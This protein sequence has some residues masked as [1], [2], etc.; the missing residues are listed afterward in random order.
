MSWV[1]AIKYHFSTHKIFVKK[2]RNII[3]FYPG[4]LKLYTLAF[5]HRSA[6]QNIKNGVKNSNERL[7][8][9]GDAVLGVVVG[10]ILFKK[11]PYKNEGFLTEMRSKMV[12][13]N[14]LNQLSRKIGIDELLDFD[15][16]TVQMNGKNSSLYG[17]AFEAL[18]GAIY[19]DKGYNF[20]SK[21]LK[22]RILSHHVDID[23]LEKTET[24]FKSKLL[25]WSQRHSKDVIFELVHSD[26]NDNE[27][28][29]T[30]K[31]II[32]GEEKASG[33][34]FNKKNAEKIAAEK[35]CEL[36]EI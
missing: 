35:T 4:N 27:K 7:E 34:D 14:H 30:I 25:E 23:E 8:F 20:T 19:I 9:L 12:N 10:E 18:I 5:R 2:L 36:L 1:S 13:R 3:G 31:V 29:F 32:D 15:S 22:N 24:N 17:D 21:F 33:Q 11:Y 16:K 28:L 26:K 6:A